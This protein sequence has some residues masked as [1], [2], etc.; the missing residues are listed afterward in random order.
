[1]FASFCQISSAQQAFACFSGRVRLSLNPAWLWMSWM[2]SLL[3][4]PSPVCIAKFTGKKKYVKVTS[5]IS[6]SFRWVE[7]FALRHGSLSFTGECSG[8]KQDHLP[9]PEAWG[10]EFLTGRLLK[11]PMQRRNPWARAKCDTGGQLSDLV[12]CSSQAG[13][14]QSIYKITARRAKVSIKL[15]WSIFKGS[16]WRENQKD[17]G[18]T[19][20]RGIFLPRWTNLRCLCRAA[21]WTSSF[22]PWCTCQL[23]VCF[24]SWSRVQGP[25][26]AWKVKVFLDV[27]DDFGCILGGARKKAKHPVRLQCLKSSS[28]RISEFVS[29]WVTFAAFIVILHWTAPNW[30]MQISC[31]EQSVHVWLF[32]WHFMTRNADRPCLRQVQQLQHHLK[33]ICV[34]TQVSPKLSRWKH[35][36]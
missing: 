5:E 34:F 24:S 36:R 13:G 11:T 2:S 4:A 22:R 23:A 6:L 30:R 12:S 27:S 35:R 3:L 31:L 9:R 32:R 7:L 21:P 10:M 14:T 1:M 18:L 16:V 17:W 20:C 28:Q 29:F 25:G 15:C 33:H 19:Y 8:W 26:Q